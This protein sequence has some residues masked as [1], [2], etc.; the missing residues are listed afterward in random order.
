MTALYR[1]FADNG[2][3]LYV[4]ISLSWP[5]RT[6][7]HSVGSHWFN[8]VAK[9][10]IEHFPDRNAAL[11]AER[12]A[13]KAEHPKHNVVHNNCRPLRKSKPTKP[14]SDPLLNAV[15]GRS[16]IVGPALMYR[17]DE[18][19][20]M[21]ASG[22]PGSAGTISELRLGTYFEVP[23]NSW[24][25]LC[26]TVMV[27]RSAADITMDEAQD[28]RRDIIAKLKAAGKHVVACDTDLSLAIANASMFPS[29]QARRILEE[30]SVERGH[31]A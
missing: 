16:A 29:D 7:Q 23:D 19:S 26:A 28:R 30:V 13:I 9:V 12:A 20:V 2:D 6:K 25:Y 27:I 4:G 5:A 17:D 11:E 24:Y 1:H 3:L 21:V 22:D 31:H 18:V 15:P 14:V 10:E 8:Q